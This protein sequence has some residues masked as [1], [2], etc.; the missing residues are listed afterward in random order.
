MDCR[1]IQDQLSAALD[2]ELDAGQRARVEE[3]VA[4]CANCRAVWQSLRTL[5][6]QVR[7]A[8][9]PMRERAMP[10]AEAVTSRV[11]ARPARVAA[12]SLPRTMLIATASMAFGFLLAVMILDPGI[13]P[14][15]GPQPGGTIVV[16]PPRS[17]AATVQVATGPIE[18]ATATPAVWMS[19]P[20]PD[21]FQCEPGVK[22][23]TP[24]SVVCELETSDGCVVRMNESTELSFI[25]PD[26]VE[27]SQGEIW[28]R[29]DQP[30]GLKVTAVEPAAPASDP[31]SI[32]CVPGD[33]AICTF[34]CPSGGGHPR[35]TA[36]SG[37]VELVADGKTERIDEGATVEVQNGTARPIDVYPGETLSDR[38]MHPLLV[39]KGPADPELFDRVDQLLAQVGHAKVSFLFER[40]LRSLGEYGALPLLRF[41]Q[42]P[43][44]A[45]DVEKRH[46]AAGILA[47]VAPAWMVPDLIGLLEDADATVRIKA[48]MGLARLTGETQGVSPEGWLEVG[49]EQMAALARWQEWWAVERPAWPTPPSGVSTI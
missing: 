24:A 42:S 10:L 20:Q 23:R 7:D 36:A 3:H 2:G 14:P 6:V 8:A 25:A 21:G 43:D 35:I 13:A 44:S 12:R 48:A 5:D 46:A 49:E 29:T 16:V 41:V 9:R 19:V 38:W 45:E 4:G 47:D 34:T 11:T 26:D 18:Y 15:I 33:L 30:N 31:F 40:D 28:C 39:R 27:L 37:H 1:D 17:A 22:V 32:R